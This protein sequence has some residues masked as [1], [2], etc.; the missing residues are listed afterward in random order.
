MEL[1]TGTRIGSFRV[2]EHV[3]TGTA[4]VYRARDEKSGRLVAVKVL[5]GTGER[6]RAESEAVARLH[7]PRIVAVIDIQEHEIGRAHV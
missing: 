2:L 4:A 1:S 7:H 6:V 3:G 5:R